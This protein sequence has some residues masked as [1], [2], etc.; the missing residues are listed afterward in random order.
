M[1]TTYYC[2]ALPLA[3]FDLELNLTHPIPW[4]NGP[5]PP[6][7]A[8]M[9]ELFPEEVEKASIQK[10][11]EAIC[12]SRDF[13]NRV[14]VR[15]NNDLLPADH[16]LTITF[17]QRERNKGYAGKYLTYCLGEKGFYPRKTPQKKHPLLSIG[18]RLQ[19]RFE[20][21]DEELIPV[22]ESLPEEANNLV[23]ARIP[24]RPLIE[25]ILRRNER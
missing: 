20:S 10:T 13:L 23:V 25:R 8:P 2:G 17:M 11:L 3:M 7:D 9:S 1:I 21:G 6:L 16:Y 14:L 5:D 12:P 18:R 22:L 19:R 4:R 15:I 24:L